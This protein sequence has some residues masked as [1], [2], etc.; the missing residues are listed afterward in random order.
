MADLDSKPALM[1]KLKN[2]NLNLIR[3]YCLIL[4]ESHELIRYDCI[5]VE[6]K[7]QIVKNIRT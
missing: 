1:S 3:I 2:T 5:A 4:S 7:G 6:A